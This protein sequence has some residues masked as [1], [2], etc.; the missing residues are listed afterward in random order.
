MKASPG[1]WPGPWGKR[2]FR[3]NRSFGQYVWGGA[4]QAAQRAQV[5]GRPPFSRFFRH[6]RW[7][8]HQGM[9]SVIL[10]AESLSRLADVGGGEVGC[11]ADPGAGPDPPFRRHSLWL[12]ELVG[13]AQAVPST[14]TGVRRAIPAGPRQTPQWTL[15][16]VSWVVLARTPVFFS[17]MT[18][19]PLDSLLPARG[20]RSDRLI[21]GPG[22]RPPPLGRPVQPNPAACSGTA[23][24]RTPVS[25]A[26]FPPRDRPSPRSPSRAWSPRGT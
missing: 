14:L 22:Q 3:K 17:A 18:A 1:R 26:R 23:S 19:T 11:T 5:H 24:P 6:R 12:G 21:P 4:G 2:N 20:A 9:I 15:G 7:T 10:F 16:R 13:A 8:D 25:A